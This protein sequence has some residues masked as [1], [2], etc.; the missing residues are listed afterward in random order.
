MI[1]TVHT[2]SELGVAQRG[3]VTAQDQACRLDIA[4]RPDPGRPISASGCEQES[5]WAEPCHIDGAF[6]ADVGNEALA[7]LGIPDAQ[8]GRGLR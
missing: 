1:S 3:L 5:P 8:Y 4:G 2:R 6:V 7:R